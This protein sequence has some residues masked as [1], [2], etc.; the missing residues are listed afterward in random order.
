[1]IQC[2]NCHS[3]L[4]VDC[5]TREE[6]RSQ[7]PDKWYCWK[8]PVGSAPERVSTTVQPVFA[9]GT[10]EYP[11]NIRR[12]TAAD[13]PVYQASDR[14]QASPELGSYPSAEVASSSLLESGPSLAP[15][16]ERT[17]PTL[18]KEWPKYGFNMWG[19]VEA[20]R[21]ANDRLDDP[22]TAIATTPFIGSSFASPYGPYDDSPFDHLQSTPNSNFGLRFAPPPSTTPR[23]ERPW[24][25]Y[26]GSFATPTNPTGPQLSP[27]SAQALPIVQTDPLFI[28]YE[29][30]APKQTAHHHG[31]SK[32]KGKPKEREALESDKGDDG[33]VQ[34]PPD[35]ADSS[36]TDEI[37]P[38]SDSG[39]ADA[40]TPVGSQE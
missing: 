28:H 36:N 20:A 15:F 21:Q 16:L 30:D 2:D 17:P 26:I 4:H 37:G 39:P 35:S 18:T 31:R 23:K 3:W 24:T 34:A 29:H 27:H 12:D 13:V 7:L 9:P 25:N 33:S 6:E 38:F 14:Q 22:M 32:R 40:S 11:K 5:V 19:E 10:P 1:M 8:C